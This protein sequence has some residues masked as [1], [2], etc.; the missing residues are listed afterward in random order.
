MA[1]PTK[2]VLPSPEAMKSK[3]FEGDPVTCLR[4]LLEETLQAHGQRR[5]ALTGWLLRAGLEQLRRFEKLELRFDDVPPYG[6]K[7]NVY[8]E[9]CSSCDGIQSVGGTK[10]ASCSSCP[11]ST[12][13]LL[14]QLAQSRPMV[15][16]PA[17]PEDMVCPV[18]DGNLRGP[19][20]PKCGRCDGFGIVPFKAPVPVCPTCHGF[21]QVGVG[22]D[23]EECLD[24]APAA[25]VPCKVRR[26][27]SSVKD[28][29]AAHRPDPGH[30]GTQG[31]TA[32]PKARRYRLR[33]R[34]E[35]ATGQGRR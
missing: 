30:A 29:V 9:G 15:A 1:K 13:E 31:D 35:D 7:R 24:C 18:C 3:Y 27:R 17:R 10:C 5:H 12:H 26:V 19:N 21:R 4:Q 25:P 8:H 11:D 33:D 16:V 14:E 34:L 32:T 23:I 28:K 20:E 2:E 22:L 6:L